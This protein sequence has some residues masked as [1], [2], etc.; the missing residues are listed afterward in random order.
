VEDND[1]KLAIDV[2]ECEEAVDAFVMLV[3]LEVF[4]VSSLYGLDADKSK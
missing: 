2:M 1:G 4:D 3:I